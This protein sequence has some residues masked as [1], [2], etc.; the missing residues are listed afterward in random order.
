[1]IDIPATSALT[2]RPAADVLGLLDAALALQV[3]VRRGAS[4]EFRHD[5]LR[6]VLEDDLPL[7]ERAALHLRIAQYREATTPDRLSDIARHRLAALPLGDPTAALVAAEAAA[8]VA[9]QGLAA[10]DAASWYEQALAVAES[11]VDR[12]RLLLGAGRAWFLSGQRD[13]AIER[14]V[15]AAELA[16]RAGDADRLARAALAL[17]ESPDVRWLP[18]VR[19]WCESALAGLP[20][21]DSALRAQVL[22]QLALTDI[23]IP[24]SSRLLDLS[25]QALAMAERMTMPCGS[26][27]GPGRS[28][29]P[30]RKVRQ[31]GGH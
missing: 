15:E 14:C 28:P 10:E 25:A 8:V 4:F 21:A 16:Q 22:A 5:L 11:S 6:E 3:L 7:V 18:L 9:V 26:H 17:P 31:S 29:A 13:R 27:C 23:F 2:N 30:L 24:E 1:M 20:E 12:G 19:S